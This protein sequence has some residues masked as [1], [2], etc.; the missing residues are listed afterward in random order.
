[1]R[2]VH[3]LEF[4]RHRDG[5]WDLPRERVEALA[6]RFPGVRF[7]TPRDQAEADRL[8]PEV[9]V[10]LGWALNPDNFGT[11]RK[12]E[13]VH[14]TAAGVGSVL[15]P[16]MV[17]SPVVLTNSRG[18]HATSMAEH[19][20]AVILAFAR[21]LHLA[22][23]AQR[24]RRWAQASLWRD[25][26]EIRDLEGST[27]GLV[28]LG[29]V[30]TA[31]ARRARSLGMRVLAVRRHPDPD[32]EPAH[33]QWGP[34]GLLRLLEASDWVVL[35]A[36]LTAGTRRLIGARELE[37]MRPSAVLVNIGRGALVDES[38][39][40]DALAAGRLAGAALDVYEEEPLPDS[41]P[42]WAMPQV[43]VTPHV[44]GVGP[45]YWERALEMFAAN[46]E[47]FV[48]GRP[49]ENVVDKAAGY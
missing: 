22:R 29:A 26:P 31:I 47:R 35:A 21:K 9:E 8:L 6:P 1:M 13:W 34:D 27:L 38:A 36:P 5:V 28:G 7:S 15:F 19:T 12:L 16:A 24:E 3:V 43:I 45:R 33:A 37:R 17:A 23:D 30:G 48:E 14:V 46:L 10:V 39:V 25:E 2:S 41:S 18:M 44:S 49:L 20:L 4:V 42:L 32:P 40:T 11:T